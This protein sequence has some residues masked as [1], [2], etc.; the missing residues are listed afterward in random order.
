MAQKS[1]E[2]QL[3]N[4]AANGNLSEVLLCLERGAAINGLNSYSR[5]ALQ[6][7]MLGHSKLVGE[8]LRA[9][10]DPSVRDPVCG[11][12]VLHDAAREGFEDTVRVL[13]DHGAD[14][15]VTDDR[16]YL[17]LHLADMKGHKGVVE[18]L[19]GRTGDKRY[20]AD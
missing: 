13:L 5:N 10:A 3:C 2:D 15:N 18:L 9:G 11:L 7:A 12:T 8:L 14:L 16:G 19:I 17:P 20:K 6:V 4:A 1:L